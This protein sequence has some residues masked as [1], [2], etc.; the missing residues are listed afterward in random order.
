MGNFCRAVFLIIINIVIYFKRT[1]KTRTY[2]QE[3]I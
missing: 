1:L 3:Y 2:F